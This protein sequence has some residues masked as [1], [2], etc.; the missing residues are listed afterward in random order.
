MLEAHAF[1]SVIMPGF[2][3]S[4]MA[5]AASNGQLRTVQWLHEKG[6]PLEEIHIT[7]AIGDGCA[8]V[9]LAHGWRMQPV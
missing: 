4:V 6:V 1:D 8:I 2:L 9:I 7:A 5:D 3:C